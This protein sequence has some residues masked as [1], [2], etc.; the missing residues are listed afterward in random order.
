[1]KWRPGA[2]TTQTPEV[3][4][5]SFGLLR[6]LRLSTGDRRR[7]RSL[8]DCQASARLGAE[9]LRYINHLGPASALVYQGNESRSVGPRHLLLQLDHILNAGGGGG[10]HGMT[11]GLSRPGLDS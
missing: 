8:T 2:R 1:M 11:G 4:E 3:L 7:S 9:S 10:A 5:Q 6:L